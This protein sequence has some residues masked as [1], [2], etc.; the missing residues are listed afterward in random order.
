MGSPAA[1]RV[2]LG[3]RVAWA[4]LHLSIIKLPKPYELGS[5]RAD[6]FLTGVNEG[7]HIWHTL[8]ET[9]G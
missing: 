7:R 3:T 4:P 6:E 9:E 8:R 5:A 1:S 2:A